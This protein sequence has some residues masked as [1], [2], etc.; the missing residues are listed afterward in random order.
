M[1]WPVHNYTDDFVHT[2]SESHSKLTTPFLL[3]IPLY[4]KFSSTDI[5]TVV[6]TATNIYGSQY[7][8][9]F[10]VIPYFVGLPKQ[11]NGGI[12]PT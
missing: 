9:M 12:F 3:F 10:P 1:I 2:P 6:T 8:C 4:V 7:P 11:F 5:H